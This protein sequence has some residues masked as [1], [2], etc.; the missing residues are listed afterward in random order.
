MPF[1]KER[2]MSNRQTTQAPEKL[3][4]E[5]KRV[6][7]ERLQSVLEPEHTGRFVAIEPETEAYFLGD[8]GSEAMIAAREAMPDRL[9]YLA[10]IGYKAADSLGGYGYRTR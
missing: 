5:G 2:E 8:T 9:F 10:R 6:Y 4:E 3:I 7:T 1:G